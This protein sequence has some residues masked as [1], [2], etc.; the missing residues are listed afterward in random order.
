MHLGESLRIGWRELA[1]HK[2]RSSLTMLGVIF[3]VA[4]VISTSA[5]GAG[6][7]EELA[8]QL[9]ELGSNTVRVKKATLRGADEALAQRQAP[10]GLRRVDADALVAAVPGITHAAPLK[11]IDV[12]VAA[13][14]RTITAEV[15]GTN[16]ALPDI[17]GY[18]VDQGRFLAALDLEEAKRVVVIGDAVRRAAFPLVEPVGQTLLVDGRPFAVV[19]TLAPRAR[20]G[21]SV[22]ESIDVD[23]AVFLP[24]TSALRRVGTDD[25]R[26]EQLD[27]IILKSDGTQPLRE[28]AALAERILLRRQNNVATFRVLVPEELIRQQQQTKNILSQVLVFIAAISL[29]VGGIGIMNIMLAS[30]TQ[31]TREIGIRRALGATQRDILSQFIIESLLISIFGGLIGIGL[32]TGLARG[33]SAYA[34]WTTIVP[35]EAVVISV[36]VAAG[37][38]FFFGF[39]PSFKASRLDPIEALRSE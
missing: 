13:E 6:A 32:G 37:V 30:V 1:M 22:V 33:I 17:V 23:R 29:L 11:I 39:Y 18:R 27:E 36:T 24:L 8:R 21:G 25:P 16:E 10:W 34:G 26:N 2:M 9:A 20:K 7:R 4:A 31:R 38:G 14:G 28:S 19:G 35:P 3:G 12:P 5:I 15:Y